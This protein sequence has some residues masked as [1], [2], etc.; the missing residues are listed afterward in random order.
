MRLMVSTRRLKLTAKKS[1]G[2]QTSLSSLIRN[3][4]TPDLDING[5]LRT[6]AAAI[7]GAGRVYD[8]KSK[9]P[10][11][12]SS[13]LK[14]MSAL[15]PRTGIRGETGY[16]PAALSISP[17]NDEFRSGLLHLKVAYLQAAGQSTVHDSF[18]RKF[19]ME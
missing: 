14:A 6:F 3:A 19:L 8:L 15:K 13:M 17:R 5:L 2:G 10:R 18:A 4:R 9:V 11:E 16:L 1:V 12:I 7:P